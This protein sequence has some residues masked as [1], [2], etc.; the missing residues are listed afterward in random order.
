MVRASVFAATLVEITAAYQ[1]RGVTTREQRAL[2]LQYAACRIL[3]R[4]GV[5]VTADGPLPAAGLLV[6]NHLSYLD[7]LVYASLLPAVFVSKREVASWPVF[8]PLATMAG[9]IY[10]D[11]DRR[12][13]RQNASAQMEE[14]L[15]AG[16]PVVLFP[17]GTSSDGAA[18]LPFHSPYFEPAV[19]SGAVITAAAIAYTSQSAPEQ[20]LAYY[21]DD[22]FGPHL[23]RTVGQR[24]LH[25]R[26][27][28]SNDSACYASRKEA[29]RRA[30]GEVRWLR[31]TMTETDATAQSEE[32]YRL[33][34][35]G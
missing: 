19:R 23:L 9:T 32:L 33:T 5:R 7:V 2:W 24:G 21:G 26:V 34:Q 12:P 1:L 35:S 22:V 3:R 15:A 4:I 27:R 16:L 20:D 14:A 31:A 18:L 13:E 8:G 10:V 30:E 6:S 25:A 11:R 29:A 17:E 28:F